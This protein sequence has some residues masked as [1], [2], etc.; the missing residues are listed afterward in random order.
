M[1]LGK[2]VIFIVY[3]SI[4]SSALALASATTNRII[5]VSPSG[6]DALA[7][8]NNASKPF[9]TFAVACQNLNNGDT[10]S[11][12]EGSYKINP[13]FPL[14]FVQNPVVPIPIYNKTNLVIKG[15]G[16]VTIDG[17]GPGNFM[18]IKDCENVL[19]QNLT[20]KG[21][22]PPVPAPNPNLELYSMIHLEGTNTSIHINE[23]RFVG[24]GNHGISNLL[25][26]KTSYKMVVSNCYFADGGNDETPILSE[27]GAAIS[28]ISSGSIIT[29]NF[30]ERCFRGIEVEGAFP[31]Y[32]VTNV[33]IANNLLT[34]CQTTG[35]MLFGTGGDPGGYSDIKIIGNKIFNV[36]NPAP[37]PYQLY[38]ASIWL[39]AGNDLHLVGNTIE[40]NDNGGGISIMAN[41]LPIRNVVVKSNVIK[42]V[43]L[44]GIQVLSQ[45]FSLSNAIVEHNRI[46]YAADQGIWIAANQASCVGNYISNS[47]WTINTANI[48]ISGN[49][50]EVADNRLDNKDLTFADHGIWIGAGSTN[51][52]IYG[53]SFTNV[54]KESIRIDGNEIIV[55]SK[56]SKIVKA[57]GELSL[58]ISGVPEAEH[59]IWSSSDQQ[60][61]THAGAAICPKEGIFEFKLPPSNGLR[62]PD[63]APP[64]Q[65]Y[66]ITT[67]N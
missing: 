2:W 35:I 50:L 36:N 49:N 15:E 61:W 18:V 5:Y 42:N 4:Y 13:V 59:L 53:N 44:R 11:I 14:W 63:P 41:F 48:L 51:G 46:E 25:G 56:I 28:G 16:I 26:P 6:D 45:A 3:L 27:D 33:L 34:N 32:P 23:C 31:G 55:H 17:E 1:K 38:S 21:N 47:S 65:F 66:K 52:I 43:Q 10:L 7:E 24:F 9:R 54:S 29:N 67:S 19:V 8:P 37:K 58:T 12:Q 22:R 64:Y 40:G 39:G 57:E 62:R 30:I 60:E 20:F